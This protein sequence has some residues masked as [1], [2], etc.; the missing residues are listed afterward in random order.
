[1]FFRRAIHVT[2]TSLHISLPSIIFEKVKIEKPDHQD[3]G[4]QDE[5]P[6]GAFN[7]RG[8]VGSDDDSHHNAVELEQYD[9]PKGPH[10]RSEKVC[11]LF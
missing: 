7:K 4:H 9:D 2:G 1:M 3:D 6:Q 10:L 8:D 5:E 11:R